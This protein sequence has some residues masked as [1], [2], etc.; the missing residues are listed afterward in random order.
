MLQCCAHALKLE[1]KT[2]TVNSNLKRTAA[3][4]NKTRIT[5]VCWQ[6]FH[7]LRT[8]A[9]TI[10]VLSRHNV[11]ENKS[12]VQ[13]C[14]NRTSPTLQRKPLVP[15][16]RDRKRYYEPRCSGWDL[17]QRPNASTTHT[18][19]RRQTPHTTVATKFTTRV[20]ILG[21]TDTSHEWT[22]CVSLAQ[23]FVLC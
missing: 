7:P 15:R 20:A 19:T 6:T 1:L 12:T 10:R 4:A 17:I 23:D 22:C 2:R 3:L 9:F 11:K 5:R 8:I 18:K 14:S 13:I 21:P 16:C